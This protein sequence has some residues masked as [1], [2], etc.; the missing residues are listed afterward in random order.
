MGKTQDS[1][2]DALI[3][4]CH[5]T[6]T[7][8]ELDNMSPKR[9]HKLAAKSQL[10]AAGLYGIDTSGFLDTSEDTKVQTEKP[11]IPQQQ[12]NINNPSSLQPQEHGIN[13]AASHIETEGTFSFKR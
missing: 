6:I 11:Q 9:W 5:P 2:F 3:T 4:F 8:I 10:I 12:T 1:R 7:D 13:K